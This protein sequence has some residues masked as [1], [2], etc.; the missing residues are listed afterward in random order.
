M[1]NLTGATTGFSTNKQQPKSPWWDFDEDVRTRLG[2]DANAGYRQRSV[3]LYGTKGAGDGRRMGRVGTG[4]ALDVSYYKNNEDWQQVAKQLGIY[5]IDSR[6]DI[7]QMYNF[8]NNNRFSNNNGMGIGPGDGPTKPE[9]EPDLKPGEKGFNY[10]PDNNYAGTKGSGLPNRDGA[11]GATQQPTGTY[12]YSG[13]DPG[14]LSAQVRGSGKV[15]TGFYNKAYGQSVEQGEA[16]FGLADL[17]GNMAAGISSTQLKEWFDKGGTKALGAKQQKGTGGI[18]DQ[19]AA[20]AAAEEEI[21]LESL[22]SLTPPP[23]MNIPA[24]QVGNVGN[25]SGVRAKRSNNSRSGRNAR[26]TSQFNRNSFGNPKAS[27]LT[28]GGLNI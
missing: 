21:S 28:I 8:V 5:S 26:G 14:K 24:A 10:D 19:V 27:S 23:K 6:N 22:P 13:Y 18:Y 17:E 4:Q 11:P 1:R 3:G 16:G 12:D 7:N 9:P 2:N 20:A 25:A 15:S